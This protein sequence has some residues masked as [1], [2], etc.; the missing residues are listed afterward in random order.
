MA[1][2]PQGLIDAYTSGEVLNKDEMI[3]TE[4][5]LSLLFPSSPCCISMHITPQ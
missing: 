4:A 5:S 2:E 3:K 1:T